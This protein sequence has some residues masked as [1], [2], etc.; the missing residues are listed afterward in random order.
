LLGR[1]IYEFLKKKPYKTTTITY[2]RNRF[3]VEVADTFLKKM[4]GLMYREKMGREKGMLFPIAEPGV[5]AS[6]ITMMNMKFSIDILWLDERKRVVDIVERAQPSSS[7]FDSYKPRKAA[8]YVLE[9][10][11]GAIKKLEIKRGDKISF[12]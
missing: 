9:L 10:D 2:K 8:K 1:A 7:L 3:R 4:V 5:L 11:A 12:G 6:T